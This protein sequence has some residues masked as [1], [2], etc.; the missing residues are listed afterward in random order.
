MGFAHNFLLTETLQ[1]S[2][3]LNVF[4][5]E[6]ILSFSTYSEGLGEAPWQQMPEGE[7]CN[8]A[9]KLKISLMG[10]L[11]PLSR[12]CLLTEEGLHY[13][14]GLAH[15]SYKEGVIDPSMAVNY[16]GKDPKALWIDPEKRP[17]RQLTSLLSFISLTGQNGFDCYQIK[18]GLLRARKTV[19]K[20][21]IWS[22]GLSVSSNAG[23]QYA[24]GSDD[25]VESFVVLPSGSENSWFEVLKIEMSALDALSKSV[26]GCTMSYAKDQKMEGDEQAAMATNLFWQMCERE[27]QNLIEACNQNNQKIMRKKFASFAQKTYDTYCPKDTARQLD[28]WAKNKPNFSNYLSAE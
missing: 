6:T 26:Y 15:M 18:F 2:I 16:G 9:T 28:A 21:G 7:D 11:I 12:F 17:W 14:E 22:G 19:D 25:Y 4:S 3:W 10:R 20:V 5:Q 27:F 1:S 23:E 24:S 8:T 13:S